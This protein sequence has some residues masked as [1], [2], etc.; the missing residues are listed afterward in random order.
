MV[1]LSPKVMRSSKQG[2]GETKP[3]LDKQSRKAQSKVI[4][5]TEYHKFQRPSC[6]FSC[7]NVCSDLVVV[8]FHS[9]KGSF[10]RS[11]VGPVSLITV[12][13]SALFFEGVSFIVRSLVSYSCRWLVLVIYAWHDLRSMS[14]Q[15]QSVRV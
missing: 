10:V 12:L 4:S 6:F 2:Q 1:N 3:Y 8:S 13:V 15:S 9:N 14:F 11:S 5:H 7:S